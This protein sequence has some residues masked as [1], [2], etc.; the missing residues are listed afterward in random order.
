MR[1]MLLGQ[2]VHVQLRLPIADRGW[3]SCRGC[4][5]GWHGSQGEDHGVDLVKHPL[6]RGNVTLHVTLSCTPHRCCVIEQ[7][8]LE[9]RRVVKVLSHRTFRRW[10]TQSCRQTSRCAGAVRQQCGTESGDPSA[11][12]GEQVVLEM[13]SQ[14]ASCKPI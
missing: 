5:R 1:P 13:I 2:G 4:R 9:T 12:A 14:E 8:C 7:H 10:G 11:A 3:R 6:R